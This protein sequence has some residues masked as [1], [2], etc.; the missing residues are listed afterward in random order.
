MAY[1]VTLQ[2]IEQRI[3]YLNEVTDNPKTPWTRNANGSN[4]ANVGNYHLGGANGGVKLEQMVG[5]S[6]EERDVLSC[7]Y[8]TKRDL[9]NRLCAMLDGIEVVRKQL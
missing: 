1:R 3:N 6:G 7:G 5:P 2:M 8:T 9:Y 4:S